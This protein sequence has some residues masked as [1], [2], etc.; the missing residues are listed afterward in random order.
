M[1][2]VVAIY[3]DVVEGGIM[4]TIERLM[5]ESQIRG[6]RA[7]G[8][9]YLTT[10]GMET[11]IESTSADS[12]LEKHLNR[13][14]DDIQDYGKVRFIG[15]TRY[16]TTSVDLDHQP[17]YD[18]DTSLVMNGVITQSDSSQWKELFGIDPHST[19]DAS[20]IFDLYKKGQMPYDVK[21]DTDLSMSVVILKRNGRII[22]CRNHKRPGWI[23][24]TSAANY[25]ASTDDILKRALGDVTPYSINP[26]QM[27]SLEN[28]VTGIRNEVDW[29]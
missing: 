15:H 12:F 9:S 6:K 13:I 24:Q 14:C 27:Y 1:C 5:L 10:M 18:Y 25:Y 8:V 17:V 20:V 29:Q 19:N 23:L 3:S 2:G 11:I 21:T 22:V 26:A 16:S 4:S 7:T 28:P